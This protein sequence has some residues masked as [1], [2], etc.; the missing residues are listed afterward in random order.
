MKLKEE[1]I[2]SEEETATRMATL[3]QSTG[4]SEG[5]GGSSV[6]AEELK[7]LRSQ[8][9]TLRDGLKQAKKDL[10]AA[11]KN[12]EK[13]KKAREAAQEE[14]DRLEG[15]VGRAEAQ[16][17]AAQEALGR[18]RRELED[19]KRK[20]VRLRDKLKELMDADE[21]AVASK[22]GGEKDDT[23]ARLQKETEVLRAQV[24]LTHIFVSVANDFF[25]YHIASEYC[26]A[27]PV[28][29]VE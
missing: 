8:V 3:K 26:L 29:G 10:E 18:C 24:I 22:T 17:S 19:S 20:E 13:L 27:S 4:K 16:A 21:R 23:I 7:E 9:F 5:G 14:V 11:S 1:F 12:R 2:K 15:Q 28:R 25:L 6:S